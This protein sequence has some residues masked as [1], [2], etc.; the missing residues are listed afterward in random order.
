MRGRKHSRNTREY[1]ILRNGSILI[2]IIIFILIGTGYALLSTK[3]EIQGKATLIAE[4]K[5]LEPGLSVASLK[6]VNNW[7]QGCI[8][9]ITVTNNDS[10]YDEWELSFEVPE[11]TT[12]VLIH[13]SF[14]YGSVSTFEGNKVTIKM[15]KINED[16]SINW[17]APWKLNEKKEI[18][19]Q[20]TFNTIMDNVSLKNVILNNKLIASELTEIVDTPSQSEDVST[21]I[22]DNTANT[23]EVEE[24][25]NVIND[26]ENDLQNNVIENENVI[27][28]NI[29]QNSTDIDTSN[30]VSQ[31]NIE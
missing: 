17:S 23:N 30:L 31:N 9:T 14:I 2:F 21:D 22:T 3:V 28:E 24:N 26:V 25:N 13:D 27:K 16:G 5:P 11:E 18:Q 19:V 10:N 8:S 4:E 20:F 15:N 6:T 7:G 12:D 29:I 1:M